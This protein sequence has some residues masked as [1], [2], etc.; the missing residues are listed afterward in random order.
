[1]RAL[2]KIFLATLVA[3]LSSTLSLSYAQTATTLPTFTAYTF[4]VPELGITLP[5]SAHTTV[6]V[7]TYSPKVLGGANFSMKCEK[8]FGSEYCFVNWL[9]VAF[10]IRTPFALDQM[11]PNMAM[12]GYLSI[13]L[14]G[15][16]NHTTYEVAIEMTMEYGESVI[17]ITDAAS[18]LLLLATAVDQAHPFCMPR[19]QHVRLPDAT[20]F[21]PFISY[22][23]DQRDVE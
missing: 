10:T 13:S 17:R 19:W 4:A 1:M 16:T 22:S 6:G 3:A 9:A 2:V 12:G 21:T 11:V 14:P 7:T 23:L 15:E 5:Y 20:K 8:V 18:N